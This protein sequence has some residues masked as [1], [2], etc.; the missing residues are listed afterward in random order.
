MVSSEPTR[1]P[2]RQASCQGSGVE[3]LH[4]RNCRGLTKSRRTATFRFR[5]L[6]AN[7]DLRLPTR[8][9]LLPTTPFR[10]PESSSDVEPAF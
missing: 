10:A 8:T 2:R 7:E 1:S 3:D 5:E 9:D 6:L 4:R